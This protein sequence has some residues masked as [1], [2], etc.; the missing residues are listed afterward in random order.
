MSIIILTLC[1]DFSCAACQ[2]HDS[3][4]QATRLRQ[5]PRGKHACQ[6]VQ[7]DF[8]ERELSEFPH[9]RLTM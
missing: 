5:S 6:Y 9:D 3:I 1:V 4:S 2:L 8:A 7:C